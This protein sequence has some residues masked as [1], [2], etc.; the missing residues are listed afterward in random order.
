MKNADHVNRGANVVFADETLL[1]KL[2]LR[3]KKNV[4]PY[5]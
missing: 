4:V 5:S 3:I 2:E 1:F